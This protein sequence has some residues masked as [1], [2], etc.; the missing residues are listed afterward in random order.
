MGE[1]AYAASGAD[2]S[3]VLCVNARDEEPFVVTTMSGSR[4]VTTSKHS[5]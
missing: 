2:L 5:F 3:A 4:N 1:N